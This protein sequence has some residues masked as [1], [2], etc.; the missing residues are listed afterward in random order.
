ML[1]GTE[2][3]K[4]GH[5]GERSG[6]RIPTLAQLDCT[7]P[8]LVTTTISFIFITTLFEDG[9]TELQ[10]EYGPRPRV[11]ALLFKNTWCSFSWLRGRT[12]IPNSPCLRPVLIF[13]RRSHELSAN[14][15]ISFT[16]TKCPFPSEHIF[17]VPCTAICS[18][19]GK[20]QPQ[21]LPGKAAGN[22]ISLSLL[23][24]ASEL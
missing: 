20:W 23:L 15:F 14:S 11:R 13:V 24:W 6:V 2:V 12:L 22:A 10:G 7:L 19:P 18:P 16:S 1:Q 5:K 21:D 4:N 9:E 17:L 8:E 3:R